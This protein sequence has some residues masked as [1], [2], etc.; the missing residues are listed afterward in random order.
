MLELGFITQAQYDEAMA[1]TDAVYERIGLYDIDYQEANAT[2][3]SYFSD[4]VYEQVKQDLILAGYNE[5]MAE[6]LLTSG[7]LRVESTLDPKIQNILNEEYADASN[8][9]ENVKWY[10]N[11]ALTIISPDGTKNNFSKE[12][13]MTWFKQNQN[14]KFNLIFSSQDDA[15]GA[16]EP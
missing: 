11:Y 14:S 9:P 10:L 6:T 12:N 4:A 3:G 15:Y 1:D 13:M 8:Y 2:T 16:A 5:T 7:G